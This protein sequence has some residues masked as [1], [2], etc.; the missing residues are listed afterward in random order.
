MVAMTGR[1]TI[2]KSTLCLLYRVAPKQVKAELDEV[3]SLFLRHGGVG[4]IGQCCNDLHE[5]KY[6]VG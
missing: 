5:R 3:G 4:R 2:P 1:V 6:A